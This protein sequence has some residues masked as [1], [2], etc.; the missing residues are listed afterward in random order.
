LSNQFNSVQGDLDRH[1]EDY[2][3]IDKF[4]LGRVDVFQN[5][6][7]ERFSFL[8]DTATYGAIG[9]LRVNLISISVYVMALT[10]EKP[11]TT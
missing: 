3:K 10:N 4:I 2:L 1:C 5:L 7:Y 6:W 8:K 9:A 11:Y